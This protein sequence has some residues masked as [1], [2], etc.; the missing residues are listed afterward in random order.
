MDTLQK[1]LGPDHV[2]V[3]ASYNNLGTVHRGLGRFQ[4]AKDNYARALDIRLKQLGPKHVDVGASYNYVGNVY[5][6]LGDFQQ[7][8]DNHARALDIRLKRLGPEHVEHVCRMS[9]TSRLV[10]TKNLVN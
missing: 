10:D 7:A 3:A 9:R 1:Q 2:D 4:Q 5:R 6:S 8:K